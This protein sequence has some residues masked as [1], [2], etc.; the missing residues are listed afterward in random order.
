MA[1]ITNIKGPAGT[2]GTNGTNGNDGAP[3]TVW[4]DGESAPSDGIGANGDF[5]LNTTT[6]DVSKKA[7]GTWA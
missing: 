3:G 2:N 5:Y 4:F 1:V 6:G 7:G